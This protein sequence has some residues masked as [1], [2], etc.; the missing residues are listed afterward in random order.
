MRKYNA[1]KKKEREEQLD[2]VLITFNNCA[3]S[4]D[5]EELVSIL[6]SII[7]TYTTII[8]NNINRIPDERV[9]HINTIY[10]TNNL[11]NYIKIMDDIVTQIKNLVI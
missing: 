6:R 9:R 11:L 1:R 10:D 3:K 7:T 5:K 2:K 4:Y 8:N